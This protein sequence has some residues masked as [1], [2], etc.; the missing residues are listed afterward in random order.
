M[1][2]YMFLSVLVPWFVAFFVKITWFALLIYWYHGPSGKN[3]KTWHQYIYLART[4]ICVLGSV[5][6]DELSQG[7]PR[8]DARRVCRGARDQGGSDER[9]PR[10]QRVQG[11]NGSKRVKGPL[12][13][14]NLTI[15]KCGTF[16]SC[17]CNCDNREN[18]CE[19]CRKTHDNCDNRDN[20]FIQNYPRG[21]YCIRGNSPVITVITRSIVVFTPVITVITLFRTMHLNSPSG[22]G[23]CGGGRCGGTVTTFLRKLGLG[24]AA[25]FRTM[26]LNSPSG[27][28]RCSGGQWK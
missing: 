16:E 4:L 20:F 24:G 13:S 11:P 1:T 21:D 28:E 25:V 22:P 8:P 19:N 18:R 9:V 27:P 17:S 7:G 10:G 3:G 12:C 6:M 2:F 23:R 26:L 14:K 15:S 5:K